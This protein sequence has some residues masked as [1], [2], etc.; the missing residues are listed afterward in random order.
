[1]NYRGE[2]IPSTNDLLKLAQKAVGAIQHTPEWKY[3]DFYNRSRRRKIGIEAINKRVYLK[4]LS[5]QGEHDVS[6]VFIVYLGKRAMYVGIA[7]Q[8]LQKLK[9]HAKGPN[10]NFVLSESKVNSK[11]NYKQGQ[12]FT[13]PSWTFKII[14]EKN[15]YKM[16]FLE[17]YLAVALKAEW[18]TFCTY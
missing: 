7:K 1:M 3:E 11:H 5:S 17:V 13:L 8:I 16:Q 18:N 2:I 14:P 4:P 15:P 12:A 6:G 9:R 10:S